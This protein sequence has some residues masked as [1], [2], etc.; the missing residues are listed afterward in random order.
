MTKTTTCAGQCHPQKSAIKI[1]AII[2]AIAFAYSIYEPNL[3]IPL[4]LT[5]DYFFRSQGKCGS[6]IN[7]IS[8]KLVKTFKL[9]T[10]TTHPMPKQFAAGIATIMSALTAIA[11]QLDQ[12]LCYQILAGIMIFF[13]LLD[14]I[15]GFCF[16]CWI[17][18]SFK[19]IKGKITSFFK[20]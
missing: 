19:F 1:N 18:P 12:I 10:E 16:A 7:T 8:K 15:L 4:Y 13:N 17:Y 6:L 3:W 20:K 14:G 11:F 9:S 2:S 5:I